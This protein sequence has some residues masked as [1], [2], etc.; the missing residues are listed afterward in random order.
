MKTKTVQILIL[1]LGSFVS[2]AWAGTLCDQDTLALVKC[3]LENAPS[4]KRERARVQTVGGELKVA[5]EKVNPQ[6]NF[7]G[8]KSNSSDPSG[9]SVQTS[10]L[11]PLNKSG[12]RDSQ[13]SLAAVSDMKAR[14]NLLIEEIRMGHWTY[15]ALFRIRTF[16]DKLEVLQNLMAALAQ[17][18]KFYRLRPQLSAQQRADQ[19]LLILY[20]EELKVR[21]AIVEQERNGLIHDIEI[22]LGQSWT[23]ASENLPRHLEKWP[24]IGGSHPNPSSP[25]LQSVQLDQKFGSEVARLKIEEKKS[26]IWIGPSVEW[27]R[28]DSQSG[29]RAGINLNI[30]LPLLESHRAT[31]ETAIL[32]NDQAQVEAVTR[33]SELSGEW[34]HFRESYNASVLAIAGLQ[35]PGSMQRQIVQLASDFQ[36]GRIMASSYVEI[37]KSLFALTESRSELEI[38][39]LTAWCQLQ[40]LQNKIEGCYL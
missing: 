4:L 24:V 33:T 1:V 7:Q 32:A 20:L 26:A 3:I 5:A 13:I 19:A 21:S 12:V 11:F 17:S 40:A 15:L 29:F 36:F 6:L 37:L 18:I 25:L 16:D 10:L 9:D 8:L 30:N 23:P 38:K 31:A 39:S 14:N 35:S 27:S 22:Q 28:V 34:D 2:T